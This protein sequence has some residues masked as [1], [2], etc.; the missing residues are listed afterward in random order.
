MSVHRICLLHIVSAC[1]VH[2]MNA[3]NVKV[4]LELGAALRGSLEEQA[5]RSCRKLSWQVLYYIGLSLM[6]GPFI[7]HP[8]ETLDDNS[9]RLTA[10][11]PEST[12]NRL[13]GLVDEYDSTMCGVIRAAVLHGM[14]IERVE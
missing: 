1:I 8:A 13:L 11:I 3:T 10:Y 9:G 12:Y 2:S 7:H 6:T 4:N 5:E 14:A